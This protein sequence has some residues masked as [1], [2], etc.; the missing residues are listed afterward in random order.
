VLLNSINF[1]QPKDIPSQVFESI[2]HTKSFVMMPLRALQHKF[3]SK[4]HEFVPSPKDLYKYIRGDEWIDWFDIYLSDPGK[5]G[6]ELQVGEPEQIL[7]SLCTINGKLLL[8]RMMSAKKGILKFF[9]LL[10]D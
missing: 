2:R 9:N 3:N 4:K 5:E 8:E 10:R 7:E 1:K 6:L